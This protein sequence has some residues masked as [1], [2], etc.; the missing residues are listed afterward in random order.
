MEITSVFPVSKKISRDISRCIYNF[1]RYFKTLTSMYFFRLFLAETL[2][3]FCG[4]LKFRGTL[5]E[6]HWSNVSRGLEGGKVSAADWVS[7]S[8]LVNTAFPSCT[9]KPQ[10]SEQL[11]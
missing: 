8:M 5:F 1:L 2:T 3:M 6:K 4:N 7:Y 10:T 9:C 11:G